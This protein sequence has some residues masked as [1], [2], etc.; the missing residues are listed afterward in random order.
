MKPTGGSAGWECR[1]AGIGDDAEPLPPHHHPH[2]PSQ[3][4]SQPPPALLTPPRLQVGA[5]KRVQMFKLAF[6]IL[7]FC[8]VIYSLIEAL[9][10]TTLTP[11]GRQLAHNL[12]QEAAAVLHRRQ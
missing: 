3:P 12:L 9:V 11:E 6:Y 8:W 10:H 1:G 5:R 4:A 7:A 2:P